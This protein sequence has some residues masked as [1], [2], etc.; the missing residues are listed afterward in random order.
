[1]TRSS[2]NVARQGSASLSAVAARCQ[3]HGYYPM[4]FRVRCASGSGSASACA[5]GAWTQ[6][7]R[8]QVG[9]WIYACMHA[10]AAVPMRGCGNDHTDVQMRLIGRNSTRLSQNW[11]VVRGSVT[12]DKKHRSQSLHL[13]SARNAAHRAVA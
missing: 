5:C 12:R 9:V 3:L 6:R 2:N 7:A 1:M 10:R 8:V 13:A 4:H 11:A